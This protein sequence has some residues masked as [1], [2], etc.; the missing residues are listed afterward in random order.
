M[1][2]LPSPFLLLAASKIAITPWA[3]CFDSSSSHPSYNQISGSRD[4]SFR[5]DCIFDPIAVACL[6]TDFSHAFSIPPVSPLS[7]QT[8]VAI[9]SSHYTFINFIRMTE[10]SITPCPVLTWKLP[11]PCQSRQM[12]LVMS[13]RNPQG[14]CSLFVSVFVS[15]PSLSSSS[16]S[17][18]SSCN[19]HLPLFLPSTIVFWQRFWFQLCPKSLFLSELLSSM[20]SNGLGQLKGYQAMAHCLIL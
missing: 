10:F 2:P 15:L 18:F 1:F 9:L 19:S 12:S 4:M 13:Y 20:G 5:S 6:R 8:M 11:T 7:L 3:S 16:S 17:H 14:L